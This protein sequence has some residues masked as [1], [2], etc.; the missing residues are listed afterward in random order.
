MSGAYKGTSLKAYGKIFPSKS[1][2]TKEN[3]KYVTNISQSMDGL[4]NKFLTQQ[5]HFHTTNATHHQLTFLL[6]CI[7]YC[8]HTSMTQL[9]HI[10]NLT[11]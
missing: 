5:S 11:L 2:G 6:T 1:L 4:Q 10:F 8:V 7:R 3:T 9:Y